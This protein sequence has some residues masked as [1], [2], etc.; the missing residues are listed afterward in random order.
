MKKRAHSN[1]PIQ[2][3]SDHLFWDVNKNKLDID[4][5]KKTIIQRVL[6]YGLI[7]D[8]N[9]LK[10]LYGID[11]IAR[12]SINLRELDLKSATF[13]SLLSSIPIENFVC[14]TSRQSTPQHWNF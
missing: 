14:Y 7:K 4:K 13:I 1:T 12:T 5:S 2:S 10:E 3:F 8:W 9:L 6:N 11:E